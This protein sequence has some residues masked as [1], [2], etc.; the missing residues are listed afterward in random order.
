MGNKP[1]VICIKEYY[2]IEVG[3]KWSYEVDEVTFRGKGYSISRDRDLDRIGYYISIEDL[4]SHF[5][6]DSLAVEVLYLE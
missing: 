4:K 6:P 5:M 2:H 3:S 1:L